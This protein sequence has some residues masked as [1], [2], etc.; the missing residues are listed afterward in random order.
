MKTITFILLIM[1]LLFTAVG[2]MMDIT[3]KDSIGF[4]SK[5]HVWND[6]LILL[7]LAILLNYNF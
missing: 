2:G 1:A 5:S 7:L 4:L 3:K 6:G